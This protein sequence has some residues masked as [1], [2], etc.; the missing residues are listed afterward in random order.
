[1]SNPITKADLRAVAAQIERALQAVNKAQ[2]RLAG[3]DGAKEL[4]A[5]LDN[6]DNDLWNLVTDAIKARDRLKPT[7][8]Q[9]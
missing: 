4:L 9:A 6:I 8:E 2:D 5:A 1:M 3:S 7:K